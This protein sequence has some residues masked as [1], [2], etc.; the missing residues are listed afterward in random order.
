[1][2]H[3]TLLKARRYTLLLMLLLALNCLSEVCVL[4][5]NELIVGLKIVEGLGESFGF[6]PCPILYRLINELSYLSLISLKRWFMVVCSLSFISGCIVESLE[7][8]FAV[9][10]LDPSS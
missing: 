6:F 1:M 10:W 3:S 4:L 7:N 5:S 8:C 9:L 2:I